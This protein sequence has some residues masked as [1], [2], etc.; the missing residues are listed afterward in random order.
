MESI[1][2]SEFKATCLAVLEEVRRTGRPVL[3]TKRGQPIAEIV[4]AS[5]PAD[6]KR[7]LGSLAGTAHI[8]GDIVFPGS[9]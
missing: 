4:P 8:V 1:A 3:I 5:R 9:R 2:I 6:V 7:R